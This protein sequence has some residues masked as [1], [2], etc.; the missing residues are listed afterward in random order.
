MDALLDHNG[1]NG[2]KARFGH[3]F[4]DVNLLMATALHPHY[5]LVVVKNITKSKVKTDT[6][7]WR[8]VEELAVKSVVEEKEISVK[9]D[10]FLQVCYPKF[11]YSN[12]LNLNFKL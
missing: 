9:D 3:L 8:L 7:Q 11:F 10:L 12:L 4:D 5:K 1:K 2:F 6:I